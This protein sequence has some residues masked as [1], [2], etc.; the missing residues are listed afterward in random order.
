MARRPGVRGRGG[1]NGRT[2]PMRAS[3]VGR[4]VP[5]RGPRGQDDGYDDEEDDQYDDDQHDDQYDDRPPPPPPLNRRRAPGGRGGRGPAGRGAGPGRAAMGGGRGGRAT[6]E[7]PSG[8]S[9]LVF[10]IVG[11]VLFYPLCI[12]AWVQGNSAMRDINAGRYLPTGSVSA[13]RILGMIGTL[14]GAAVLLLVIL[15]IFVLA[16]AAVTMN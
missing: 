7:H 8:T 11:W 13:G 12:V 3:G 2:G 5:P 10:A 1:V 16:G 15:L 9:I 14:M 6:R 4:R